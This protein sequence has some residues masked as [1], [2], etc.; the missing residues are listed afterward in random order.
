MSRKKKKVKLSSLFEIIKF[1][2]SNNLIVIR[3][4]KFTVNTNYLESYQQF[5]FSNKNFQRLKLQNQI[6]CRRVF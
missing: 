6:N 2:L 1:F 4:S 5:Y 3:Q